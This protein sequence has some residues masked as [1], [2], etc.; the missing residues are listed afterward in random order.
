MKLYYYQHANQIKNFGDDLNPWIFNELFPGAFDENDEAVFVGIGTLLNSEKMPKTRRTIVFS[1]GV[2]YE[3]LPKVDDSWKIYCLR[4]PLT[5]QKLG[6]PED[7]AVTDGAVL[8][9]K[10]FKGPFK[11]KHKFSYCP[12]LYQ[13]INASE[14]WPKVCEALG[15]NYIDPQWPHEKVIR[16]IGDTECLITEALHGAIVADSLRIPW[17]PV[18]SNDFILEFKWRDWCKSVNIEY[19]PQHIMPLWNKKMDEGLVHKFRREFKLKMVE[20]QLRTISLTV[21]PTLS[22]T[23]RLDSVTQ[24]LE[25]CCERFKSELAQGILI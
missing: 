23:K 21:A 13:A 2:G 22:S 15:F 3:K 20:Q 19:A 9:R 11:K 17:I 7:L 10:F 18:K 14:A 6:V 4:G 16:A 25:D 1:S 5:A 8:V 24:K 12:H